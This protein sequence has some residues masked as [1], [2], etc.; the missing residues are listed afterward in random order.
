MAKTRPYISVVVPGYNDLDRM[1]YLLSRLFKSKYKNFEVVVVDDASPQD[2]SLLKRNFPIRFYRNRQNLGVAKT[3]NIVARRARGEILLSLD[4]DVLPQGDLIWQVYQFFQKYPFVVAVT[5]FAGTGAENPAF[6][7]QF[8]Y[9]RDW[10]YWYLDLDKNRFCFFRPAIGAIRRDVFLKL[11]GYDS[12]YC[13]PGVPAVEDLE[14]SYR[15]AKLG[16]IV[17]DPKLVVGHPFGGF[18]NLIKTYFNRAGLFLEILKEYQLFSG[19]ATTPAEAATILAAALSLL[20]VFLTV[21]YPSFLPFLIFALVSFIF[22]QRLFLLLCLK[23]QG[24]IFS[25][26]A[27]FTSWLLYLV[28][29]A[30]AGWAFL[31]YLL[32]Y[33]QKLSP[34]RN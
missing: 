17:F 9:L 14:F 28:I 18:K 2:L 24:W 7:A 26:K 5:G 22:R 10:A 32:K 19:V 31:L 1:G 8:K 21:I 23:K 16:K 12:H 34:P 30:G 15:L 3:R 6:F 20:A 11:R 29:L 33:G 25:L 27:F 4:N 13:R